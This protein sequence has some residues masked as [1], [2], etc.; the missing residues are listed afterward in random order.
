MTS[1][2]LHLHPSIH[3]SISH[4]FDIIMSI[5]SET[6]TSSI[7][8]EMKIKLGFFIVIKEMHYKW[9]QVLVTYALICKYNRHLLKH[10]YRPGVVVRARES[11]WISKTEACF[12]DLRIH[13]LV[14]S[15]HIHLSDL[16]SHPLTFT[17]STLE[18]L[19]SF[20][21]LKHTSLSF[22]RAFALAVSSAQ[23]V[24]SLDMQCRV[25]TSCWC[26]LPH[27]PLS[28]VFPEYPIQRSNS[29][30]LRTLCISIVLN[31]FSS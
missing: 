28:E 4:L 25:H 27:E 20:L 17:H 29:L 1:A 15:H 21:F 10:S 18:T 19:S 22:L 24:L 30:S 6:K 16:M 5:D 26:L 13:R 11:I 7:L 8:M 14:E 2:Y 23:T 12:L 9:H 3:P 31:Y